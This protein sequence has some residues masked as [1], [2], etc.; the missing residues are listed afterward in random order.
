[1]PKNIVRILH[2]KQTGSWSVQSLQCLQ[3]SRYSW[4]PPKQW[5]RW[6]CG[7][8]FKETQQSTFTTARYRHSY[9]IAAPF[10][11]LFNRL[12]RK[13]R[14]CLESARTQTVPSGLRSSLTHMICWWLVSCSLC[15]GA[16]IK[17][18]SAWQLP[19]QWFHWLI[20]EFLKL[21][22]ILVH[23]LLGD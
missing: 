9:S 20:C 22:G 10:Y 19:R 17:V 23:F 5:K 6:G 15:V 7:T 12:L 21:G 2:T 1:M 13:L 8:H 4:S 18:F 14:S 11:V 16:V 3:Y